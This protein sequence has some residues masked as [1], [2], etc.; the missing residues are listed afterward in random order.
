LVLVFTEKLFVCHASGQECLVESDR[1]VAVLTI[2]VDKSVAIEGVKICA[3]ITSINN[4][5]RESLAINI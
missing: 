3:P 4:Y 2:V 5:W 1:D